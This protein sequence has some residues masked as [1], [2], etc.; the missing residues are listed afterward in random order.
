MLVGD[1]CKMRQ[2]PDAKE[3]YGRSND[4]LDLTESK[5]IE[6]RLDIF[7]FARDVT[8]FYSFVQPLKS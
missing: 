1:A 2:I 7:N 3:S 8:A 6:Q 5:A 4:G